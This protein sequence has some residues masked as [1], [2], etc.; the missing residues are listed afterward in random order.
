MSRLLITGAS[1]TL[2]GAV[3]VQAQSAGWQ[4]AGTFNRAPR[5]LPIEWHHL[6]ITDQSEVETLV[7]RLQ[8]TAI[9]HTAA[10]QTGSNL[11]PV[12]ACGSAYMALAARRCGAR[13]VHLS[14]DALHSGQHAPYT[15]ATWPQ[16]ITPYGAAKAAAETAV[17]AID[18]AAV[19]VRT[20]LIIRPDP[21]DQ[22]SR[23]ILD[24]IAGRRSECLFIDEYRCPIE[25]TDLAAA[26]LELATHPFAGVLNVAGADT[27]TR[28]E[29][30][31]LIAC[32]HGLD[33][34][35]VPAASLAASGLHRPPDVRLDSSL[36]R[37]ILRTPLR[38][39]AAV[40]S[41]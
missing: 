4:V 13:L 6:E 31:C 22:H 21:P 7:E 25:V 38:G 33:P 36:A 35:M 16:P 9:I 18:P 20:S 2:G 32:F 30:G 5:G 28:Y 37:T 24:V 26:V 15:E 14:S 12:T 40:L 19:L 10:V 29:L 11:W 34:K 23:F 17:S 39:I 1:G 41:R 3:A 8:P 27:V